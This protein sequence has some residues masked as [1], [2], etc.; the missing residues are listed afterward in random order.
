MK[1]SRGQRN[2]AIRALNCYLIKG[3]TQQRFRPHTA[4]SLLIFSTVITGLYPGC[5]ELT[6]LVKN[7]FS[8]APAGLKPR[9]YRSSYLPVELLLE[10]S[11]DSFGLTKDLKAAGDRMTAIGETQA[12][13]QVL[14]LDALIGEFAQA[15]ILGNIPG[16]S[17]GSNAKAQLSGLPALPTAQSIANDLRTFA[18]ETPN[19]KTDIVTLLDDRRQAPLTEKKRF[20]SRQRSL[21]DLNKGGFKVLL[22]PKPVFKG[23]A[24]AFDEN[25][26]PASEAGVTD[27]AESLTAEWTLVE[28]RSSLIWGRSL[29]PSNEF[30]AL[31]ECAKVTIQAKQDGSTLTQIWPRYLAQESSK[32]MTAKPNAA[33]LRRIDR[34]SSE[35]S[36]FRVE[37]RPSA[38]L[39]NRT[40]SGGGGS[41]E[42]DPGSSGLALTAAPIKYEG[43]VI[44]APEGLSIHFERHAYDGA[45]NA[46]T[47]TL[48]HESQR[49]FVF[50][51]H[52]TQVQTTKVSN[53]IASFQLPY[54]LALMTSQS[55]R[56]EFGLWRQGYAAAQQEFLRGS[57]AYD[58]ATVPP[59]DRWTQLDPIRI[60][61]SSNRKAPPATS[62]EMKE[63]GLH[64]I[65]P[66]KLANNPSE[67]LLTPKNRNNAS[68]SEIVTPEK[69]LELEAICRR[70]LL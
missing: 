37:L 65:D 56:N 10:S 59:Q 2:C 34:G 50:K 43:L 68:D 39:A 41:G 36:E 42:T 4:P 22:V 61:D 14:D 47:Y 51:L 67:I 44:R 5:G 63:G 3:M 23:L 13:S 11:Q 18:S 38:I 49:F 35:P 29:Q 48:F 28:A 60:Y 6:K 52:S 55:S 20:D 64:R 15:R 46:Q 70:A 30:Q 7:R 53:L 19:L 21:D 40:A 54:A 27:S 1:S 24:T 57:Q 25:S 32:A 31:M 33:G 12:A 17:E 45:Q 66:S 69:Y 58:G 62:P 9:D 26:T 8:D 16:G